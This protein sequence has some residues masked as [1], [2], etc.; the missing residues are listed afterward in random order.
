MHWHDQSENKYS[1]R[2]ACAIALTLA[3][4]LASQQPHTT[5]KRKLIRNDVGSYLICERKMCCALNRMNGKKGSTIVQKKNGA[6]K[7]K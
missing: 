5:T 2:S 6:N 1:R 7:M 3:L 4:A